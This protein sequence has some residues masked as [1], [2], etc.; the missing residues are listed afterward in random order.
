LLRSVLLRSVLLLKTNLTPTNLTSYSK[1][2]R[3][4]S[5]SKIRASPQPAPSRGARCSHQDRLFLLDARHTDGTAPQ[6]HRPDFDHFFTESVAA[7][8]LAEDAWA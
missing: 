8:G 2:S 6:T 5:F 4:K 1:N 7:L 3:H